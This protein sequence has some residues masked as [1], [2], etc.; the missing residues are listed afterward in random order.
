MRTSSTPVT[1]S[2]AMHATP[3]L[4]G[5]LLCGL[6]LTFIVLGH[7]GRRVAQVLVLLLPMIVLLLLP[8]QRPLARRLR[9][10][11]M[12]LWVMLFVLDGVARGYL[13][14]TYQTAPNGALV[15]A[16]AA[17]TNL[18]ESSEYFMTQWRTLAF[19]G[20]T[21]VVAAGLAWAAAMRAGYSGRVPARHRR[22]M[23]V[24]LVLLLALVVLAYASKPW[25]RLHPVAFW[26][27]WVGSVHHLRDEWSDQL[28]ERKQALH[29]AQ[30][31]APQLTPHTQASTV[32]L[33]LGESVNRDN[34]SLYGYS[35]ATSPQLQ[36][37]QRK[38]GD[39]MLVLRNAW[40]V[41]ASTLPSLYQMF[42]LPA[43]DQLPSQH[44]LALA[45]SAGYKVW[46][47]SNQDDLAIEQQHAKLA[48]VVQLV[49]HTPGRSSESLDGVL[50]D[51][52]EAALASPQERKL[53]VVHLL[54]AHPH[55]RLRFPEDQN[56]FDDQDDTV[57][58][59]LTA[60]GR[61]AWVR[62]LRQEYD[63]ALLYHDGVVSQLLR[64]TQKTS[65][66][67]QASKHSP[68]DAPPH[69]AWMYLSDHGQEVGH[70]SNHAGHSQS[71][72]SGF[73]IPAIL[74]SSEGFA[75]SGGSPA[76]Q[77]PFRADWMAF[78]MADLL[79][80]QWDGQLHERSILS[81]NYRWE[82][83]HLPTKVQSFSR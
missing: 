64:A 34:L 79:H 49:N 46:W 42:N 56:P 7:E 48:D 82:A 10:G 75:Q 52:V 41:H 8:L 55:Y 58:K 31:L 4:A 53:I 72:E 17:N 23:Q 76:S 6:G 21:L 68:S 16:A 2:Y 36:A 74:W 47:I 13:Q 63:A 37:L 71:T 1:P 62:H 51:E 22:T 12:W 29:N 65:S 66:A 9:A 11:A 40:S 5:L 61:P 50:L 35:R 30:Q 54:G 14:D 45:R 43:Q 33:V 27:G 15:L 39:Q 80:L 32:V 83:P 69:T 44:L 78:T 73:R 57:E 3:W 60:Q 25:R 59:Q 38:S 20:G 77:R 28:K 18:R 67:A 81:P 24:V 19:W 26:T 70:S